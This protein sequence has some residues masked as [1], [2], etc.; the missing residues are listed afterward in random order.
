MPRALDHHSRECWASSVRER[1]D[2]ERLGLREGEHQLTEITAG[3]STNSPKNTQHTRI[4]LEH[5][6]DLVLWEA[7]PLFCSCSFLLFVMVYSRPHAQALRKASDSRLGLT[8]SALHPRIG[9]NAHATNREG[10]HAC[11]WTI[12]ANSWL[13]K[14]STGVWFSF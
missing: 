4:Y 7:V 11:T 6:S 5:E 3:E 9:T 12:L 8:T 13:P 10:K 1:R 14:I 2:D